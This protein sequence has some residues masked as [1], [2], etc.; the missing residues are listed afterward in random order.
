MPDTPVFDP[1]LAQS[2]FARVEAHLDTFEASQ[3]PRRQLD[4]A[5]SHAI[6]AAERLKAPDVTERLGWLDARLWDA[7]SAERLGD[8][9]WAAWHIHTK[10]AHERAAG[11]NRRVSLELFTSATEHRQALIASLSYFCARHPEVTAQLDAI[12]RGQGYLDLAADLAQLADLYTARDADVAQDPIHYT[13]QAADRARS[14]AAA[15]LTEL[16]QD[17]RSTWAT[18]RNQ[19]WAALLHDYNEVRWALSVAFRRD[20]PHGLGALPTLFQAG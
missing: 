17:T 2:A 16:N 11:D 6:Y 13:P 10:L 8:L 15:L 9:A 3:S 5:A 7:A 12:R 18:R 1:S 4:K 19:A 20:D 14:L